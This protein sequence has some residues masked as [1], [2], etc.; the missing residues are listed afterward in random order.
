MKFLSTFSCVSLR[1]MKETGVQAGRFHPATAIYAVPR[2]FSRPILARTYSAEVTS[3]LSNLPHHRSDP[4]NRDLRMIH[5]HPRVCQGVFEK[6]LPVFAGFHVFALVIFD[7]KANV[8]FCTDRTS[9]KSRRGLASGER[10][11]T[12]GAHSHPAPGP[13]FTGD[14]FLI[15]CQ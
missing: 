13:P 3:F 10:L 4:L 15:P 14:A 9:P 12:A 2:S 6:I 8:T 5:Q 7:R 11:R 1:G